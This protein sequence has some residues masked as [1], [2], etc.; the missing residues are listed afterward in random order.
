MRLIVLHHRFFNFK[1]FYR[2]TL[3][4]FDETPLPCLLN[5]LFTNE[6]DKLLQF[7]IHINSNNRKHIVYILRILLVKYH[8]L[9]KY[10]ETRVID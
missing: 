7:V 2:L 6:S 3:N 4:I 9:Y 8:T 10:I 1:L 5:E